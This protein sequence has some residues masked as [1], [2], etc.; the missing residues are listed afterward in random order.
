MTDRCSL[1]CSRVPC[2]ST[3]PRRS[4]SG[5]QLSGIALA[6]FGQG[7]YSE[8]ATLLKESLQL[9]PTVSINHA[10]LAA[11]YGHL[12]ELEGARAAIASYRLLSSRDLN[13]RVTLFRRP[14]HRK[15]YLDGIDLVN[16]GD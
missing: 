13:E 14:E 6:R 4:F 5:Y 11:C 1:C 7:R 10:L 8:A 9:Q 16:S 2:P 12:G 3:T 15:A